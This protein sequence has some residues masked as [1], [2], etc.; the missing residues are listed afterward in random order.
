MFGTP[1]HRVGKR[2]KTFTADQFLIQLANAGDGEVNRGRLFSIVAS[3]PTAWLFQ[4]RL[5]ISEAPVAGR[6]GAQAGI[7]DG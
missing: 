7:A 4:W 1:G 6:L 3:L 5:R 2:L